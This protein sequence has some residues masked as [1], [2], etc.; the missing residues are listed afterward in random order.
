LGVDLDGFVIILERMLVFLQGCVSGSSIA[1]SFC[2][3]RINLDPLI[4][5]DRT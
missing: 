5:L 3:L 1:V 4:I 2:V